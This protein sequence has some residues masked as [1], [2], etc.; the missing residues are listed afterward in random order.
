MKV[1][2]FSKIANKYDGNKYRQKVEQDTFLK[3][4]I[5]QNK[6]SEYNILDLACGTGIYICKQMEYF[7]SEG[8]K[9]Y[10]LDASL[11][12]LEKAKE[13]IIGVSFV[14]GIAESMPYESN[15]FDFIVNNYAFQHFTGKAEALDEVTRVL[16]T[17]GIFEMHNIAIH[18]MKSWWV[19][20]YFPSAYFEDLKRFWDKDLIFHELSYRGFDV[21]LNIK[22]QMQQMKAVDLL[23]YAKNRDISVLTLI[24]EDEYLRGLEILTSDVYN[25]PE[26]RIVCDFAELYCIAKKL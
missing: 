13:K 14:N 1:A 22:Y 24:D 26:E 9:W 25:N 5:E 19:Y 23:E 10:G 20:K 2:D 21:E 4:Y 3:T 12:M 18:Q 8:I 6:Q 15:K 16:K 7:R 17:N 11:D